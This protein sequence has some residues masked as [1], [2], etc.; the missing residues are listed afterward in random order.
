VDQA[1]I[2]GR[3]W[4][5][6]CSTVALSWVATG[7]FQTR[8]RPGTVQLGQAKKKSN[9][10]PT[11]TLIQNCK[12]GKEYLQSLKN[13]QTLVVVDKLKRNIFPFGKK[14]KFQTDFE[15]KTQESNAISNLLEF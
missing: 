4:V 6:A 8:A 11:I 5:R 12:I 3:E 9:E 7:P 10:F 2:G 15:I 1:A 13:L 14:F